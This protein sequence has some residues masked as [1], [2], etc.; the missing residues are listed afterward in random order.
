MRGI[1]ILLIATLSPLAANACGPWI[2]T[3]YLV[4][5]DHDFFTPPRLGFMRELEHLLPEDIPFVAVIKVDQSPNA[6]AG[7]EATLKTLGLSENDVDATLSE[8][9][10]Y[11]QLLNTAK[12]YRHLPAHYSYVSTPELRP[13]A[14]VLAELR[15]SA[16]PRS[17]PEEFRLYLCG[18]R[19]YY[20]GNLALARS[21]WANVL[22]LPIGE[23]QFQS[24]PAAYMLARIGTDLEADANYQLVRD[25]AHAGLADPD[26]LAAASY[27]FQAQAA[28]RQ[29]RYQHAVEL[30]LTQWQCGYTNAESS[31]VYTAQ[32]IWEDSTDNE[33]ALYTRNG[34]LRAVLTASLLSAHDSLETQERRNRL[35][36]VLPRPSEITFLEAGRFALLEYQQNNIT[37]A[38]LWLE[39]A[40]PRDALA[41]W[42]RS[43]MMLRDGDID[44]GRTILV[45]LL[46]NANEDQPD[47][48]R[49]DTRRAWGELG[50]L[51]MQK[52]DYADAA[53]CFVNAESWL[54]LA[55]VL[56]RV[57]TLE[58][59]RQWS[60]FA[61]DKMKSIWHLGDSNARRLIAR[62]LMR[63][64]QFDEALAFFTDEVRPEALAYIESMR[65]ASQIEAP[66]YQRAQAYWQAARIV[67]E[68]G[69]DLFAA[70]LEPDYAWAGG[71]F[72]APEIDRSP[73][74]MNSFLSASRDEQDRVHSS[75]VN[76]FR[77]H[78]YRYRAAQLAE[79]AAGL[80]PNNDENAAL[81]YCIAGGWLKHRDP[82]SADRF[83]KQLVVRCPQTKLG[84]IASEKRWFPP[85]SAITAQPFGG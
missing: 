56:E 79:L 47:W 69:L 73:V 26:G 12:R 74:L 8:Y 52:H 44:A 5:N 57:M 80:L 7:L 46:R 20:L 49:L 11:R 63:E 67:R 76:P 25:L 4:R 23:R 10:D 77:R 18:A 78:H 15:E 6:R 59:L 17:L 48:E 54:D 9:R 62:R 16:P 64:A 40:S 84:Q 83:Y 38:R 3:P 43:K 30:Y 50:L 39:F 36:R 58:E 2:P 28:L 13:E 71:S 70:E 60:L 32:V 68:H 33:L 35:L 72:D 53:S 31:L 51:M 41:L 81:I 75:E 65:R 42:V 34:L 61:P 66:A 37:A 82:E 14:E 29:S 85:D 24:I 21:Y 19:E 45:E 55:Y 27:G 1:S 22:A